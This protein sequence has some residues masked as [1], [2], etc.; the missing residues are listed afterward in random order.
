MSRLS[1]YLDSLYQANTDHGCTAYH[2][3]VMLQ[4]YCKE[5]IKS[6]R[7]VAYSDEICFGTDCNDYMYGTDVFNKF[8]EELDEQT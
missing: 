4:P 3:E 8:V 1:K 6:V 7:A 2:F 5:D